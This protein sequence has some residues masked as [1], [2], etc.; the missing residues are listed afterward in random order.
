MSRALA[1]RAPVKGLA[2][3]LTAGSLLLVWGVA[4]EALP[5]PPVR[6]DILVS[7]AVV[8]SLVAALVWG[9]SSLTRLGRRLAYVA[10]VALPA[11]VV[12]VWLG[13]PAPANVAKVVGAA[14][15][16]LWIALELERPSWIVIVAVVSAA[17]DI[18]SVA[19]G[20][21]KAILAKGPLVVGYF[22][23]VVTWAGYSV[24]EAFTGLGVSDVVF[25]ALYVGAA[26]RFG[27]R[28]GWSTAAMTAS[29]LATVTAAMYWT[30]LPAL[31]LLSVAFLAVNGDLLWRRLRARDD[32]AEAR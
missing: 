18:F 2:P 13:W 10:L 4:S 17:V 3:A 25:F 9:M 28:A 21:T 31:P 24:A 12:L 11:A 22:T 8:F 5:A 16:G 6:L 14:A 20:P 15:L 1:T 7:S 30:A 29:F 23:V 26:R 19:A 32:G 27:L